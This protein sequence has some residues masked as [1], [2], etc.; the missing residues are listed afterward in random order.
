MSTDTQYLEAQKHVRARRGL[1]VHAMLY[2]IVNA[3]LLAVD[4]LTPGGWWFFW[5]AIGWGVGLAMNALAVLGEERWLG[6]AWER[7]AIERYL[8]HHPDG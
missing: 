2:A 7:R 3:T 6:A 5:P 4:A 8:K 1:Y